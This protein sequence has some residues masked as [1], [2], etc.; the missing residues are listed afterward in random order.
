MSKTDLRVTA[1]VNQP[2]DRNYFKYKNKSKP[3]ETKRVTD[4]CN[5]DID[6]EHLNV[7]NKRDWS[8]I[9]EHIEQ[10]LFEY[11][12]TETMTPVSCTTC[13]RL[14]EYT[15]TLNNKAWRM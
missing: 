10:H 14:L 6:Y 2:L 8:L 13:G 12:S 11:P 5:V 4:C 3:K 15:S 9:E 1:S 7:T